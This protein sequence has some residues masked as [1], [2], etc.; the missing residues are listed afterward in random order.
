MKLETT[1]LKNLI[2][3][4][5]YTRKVIPFIQSSYFS[6][7]KERIVFEQ[8]SEFIKKYKTLPTNE[9]LVIDITESKTLTDQEVKGSLIL[10]QEIIESKKEPTDIQWLIEQTEKFCQDKALYNAIMESVSILDSNTTT[11]NKGEIPKL[12]SNALGVSFD[13]HVGHDY[14]NDSES[15]YD[16]YHKQETRIPFDIDLLNKITKGGIPNKTLNICLAGCV[17]PDT[18]V[19]I[20]IKRKTN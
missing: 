3:C 11:K 13:T 12:L 8:I 18:K 5:E 7:N 20:R 17:H 4:D 14:I 6:E 16:F 19:K 9:A 1:I 15:R 10:L 2:F